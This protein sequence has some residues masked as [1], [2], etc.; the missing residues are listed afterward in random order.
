MLIAAMLISE[1]REATAQ[2]SRVSSRRTARQARTDLA[3][4]LTLSECLLLCHAFDQ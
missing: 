2:E 3:L 1:E 4:R